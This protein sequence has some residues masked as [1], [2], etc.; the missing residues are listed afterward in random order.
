MLYSEYISNRS[1]E[2]L[3]KYKTYR[4]LYNST[5]RKSKKSYFESKLHENQKDPKATWKFLNEAINRL[6][7]KSSNIDEVKVNDRVITDPVE[8]ANNF[9]T[10][11]SSIAKEIG[12]KIPNTRYRRT[13]ILSYGVHK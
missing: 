8:I 3:I 2:N 12:D 5:L 11:F 7:S 9:N 4:N 6:S 13:R 1:P 10:F